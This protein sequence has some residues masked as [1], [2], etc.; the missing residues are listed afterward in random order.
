[1]SDTKKLKNFIPLSRDIFEHHLWLEK[2]SFSRCEAWIY[3]IKEA[4]FEDTKLLD[5]GKLVFV[6]RGQIYAS[7]RFL[8][9]AWKWSTT[10][11]GSFLDMLILDEMIKKETVKETGQNMITICNYDK[12]NKSYQDEETA[13]K[14][15][16]KQQKDA[17]KTEGK[18]RE[19]AE[20]TKS[21]IENIDNN[22]KNNKINIGGEDFFIKS[23]HIEILNE[24]QE[25]LI[26]LE[27]LCMNRRISVDE[28]KDWLKRFFIEL[29]NDNDETDRD[30][31]DY[32]KYFNRWL[33]GKM[34][35]QDKET[36]QEKQKKEDSEDNR[37]CEWEIPAFGEKRRNT[38]KQF[39][40]DQKRNSN[41]EVNFLGFVN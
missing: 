36:P 10:K 27:P 8:A 38:Y 23:Q 32:K 28:M 33:S 13:E 26:W 20:K 17:G 41:I 22:I 31:N 1:M 15:Q 19:N 34:E 14:T 6:K 12:Y 11:V 5:K 16:K 7:I 2:R 39:L 30:L 25:D 35:R 3:L 18:R 29:T 21:N 4:R 24:M 37:I 40:T 9:E